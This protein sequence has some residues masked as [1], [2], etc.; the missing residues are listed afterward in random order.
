M[1]VNKQ[2]K[3]S[4]DAKEV[5]ETSPLESKV[6]P[7]AC[8]NGTNAQSSM[9]RRK[10]LSDT[11]STSSSCSSS[12]G[13]SDSSSDTDSASSSNASSLSSYSSSST[14]PWDY[15]R[16]IWTL[17]MLVLGN[18]S[19]FCFRGI[20]SWLWQVNSCLLFWSLNW[21]LPSN[22]IVVLLVEQ[23]LSRHLP[24]HLKLPKCTAPF[25]R[26]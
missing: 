23:Y 25:A 20:G 2:L 24:H 15:L 18:A 21:F 11:S 22:Q 26:I 13:D 10:S 5:V 7:R 1:S 12:N 8:A 16:R 6:M 14:S 4:E 17:C 3:H 9:S 19:H